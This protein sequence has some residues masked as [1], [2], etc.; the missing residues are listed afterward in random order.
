MQATCLETMPLHF[1]ATTGHDLPFQFQRICT[2]FQCCVQGGLAPTRVPS[3]RA[4]IEH[5]PLDRQA[6]DARV[7]PLSE[8]SLHCSTLPSQRPP[9][10][11]SLD[12]RTSTQYQYEV[13]GKEI[14][15]DTHLTFLKTKRLP[16][17]MKTCLSQPDFAWKNRV[18][19]VHTDA[20]L[21]N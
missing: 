14:S 11:P 13:P 16:S 18:H 9:S 7:R 1:P 3:A 10:A 6:D 5:L 19:L 2:A 20:L 17:S 12:F 8:I 21:W 15:C 4:L